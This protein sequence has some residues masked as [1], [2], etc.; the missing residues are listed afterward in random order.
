MKVVSKNNHEKKCHISGNVSRRFGLALHQRNTM[1][2][3][4]SA[5]YLKLKLKL[6]IAQC[7]RWP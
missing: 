1:F 3:E 6:I 2:F 5:M 4:I 7:A